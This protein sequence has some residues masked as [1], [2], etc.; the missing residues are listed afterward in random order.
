MSKISNIVLIMLLRGE[1]NVVKLP[2]KPKYGEKYYTFTGNNFDVIN[3]MWQ[4]H[5]EAYAKLKSGMIFRTE[6][7]AIKE[8][9]RIYKELT[10]NEWSDNN[11]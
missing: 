3:G 8:R 7:E 2:W 4:H 10:G 9:P 5:A 6:A 1:Y 11:G